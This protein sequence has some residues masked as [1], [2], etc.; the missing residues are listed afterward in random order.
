MAND[1]TLGAPTEGLGQTV[2]FGFKTSDKGASQGVQRGRIRA[3]VSGQS[4]VAGINQATGVKVEESP[5][6]AML[7]KVGQSLI[8]QDIKK[9]RTAAYVGGMQRAMNG[10][11]VED[12]AAKQPAWSRVFG[13][14]DAVE[15]ARAYSAERKVQ[16]TLLTIENDM[17]NLRRMGPKEANEFYVRSVNTA[18]TG[19]PATD[20]AVMSALQRNLPGVIKRQTQMHYA[21][22]QENAAEEEAGA[23]AAAAERLQ[24][25]GVAVSKGE[26]SP[27]D[28]AERMASVSM[29]SV[30]AQGRDPKFVREQRASSAILMAEQGQFHALN[31]MEKIGLF[32]LL[33]PAQKAAVTRS[34]QANELQWKSKYGEEYSDRVA[35]IKNLAERPTGGWRAEDTMAVVKEINAEYKART[36]SQSDYFNPDIVAAYGERTAQ[37]I[38]AMQKA[39]LADMDRAKTEA[40]KASD[41]KLAAQIT[42]G[43][44]SQ[45]AAMGTLS[46]VVGMGFAKDNEVDA[47]FMPRALQVFTSAL[48]AKEEDFG[49]IARNGTGGY[50]NKMVADQLGLLVSGAV[51]NGAAS[52]TFVSVYEGWRKLNAQSPE[53]A[54]A[55]YRGNHAKFQRFSLAHPAGI[56][57]KN[58]SDYL[59]AAFNGSFGPNAE[60][61]GAKV[62]KTEFTA[63]VKQ[64]AND[65]NSWLPEQLGGD[66][67]LRPGVA[68]FIAN[69]TMHR[70]EVLGASGSLVD[71]FKAARAVAGQ[72]NLRVVGGYAWIDGKSKDFVGELQAIVGKD[73]F[74]FSSNLEVS[75]DF[76]DF[77]D[78]EVARV[79]GMDRVNIE[80][81]PD[82]L[83]LIGYKDG[84]PRRHLLEM[85][86]IAE[87]IMAV[88]KNRRNP[89]AATTTNYRPKAPDL[90]LGPMPSSMRNK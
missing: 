12:I 33:L 75:N 81:R 58:P 2:T 3:G 32:D 14:S 62:D 47:W 63:A 22:L 49:F 77:V 73:K 9:A 61:F 71:G 86:R 54:A 23:L 26:M 31:A 55:Y 83:M 20:N 88:Q 50:V 72:D 60:R 43:A 80:R 57:A 85:N 37:A 7:M 24:S 65:S 5:A 87:H 39:Q 41:T 38:A 19:D 64:I 18:L 4:G 1:N 76:G 29:L 66:K 51:A 67:K 6:V 30:P 15:G 36:G 78:A 79:G 27:E 70:A 25:A 35:A 8:D 84:Q 69:Q 34:R 74:S 13:D 11:A 21:Y 42:E 82:A 68:E 28:F 10:E 59:A 48:T 52:N 17:P 16:D 44:I 45:A 56:D 89:P 90:Q 46:T 53:A 40:L